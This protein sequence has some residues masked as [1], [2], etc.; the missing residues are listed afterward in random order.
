MPVTCC[1]L[2][3]H[4][5]T[6][7]NIRQ[8]CRALNRNHLWNFHCVNKPTLYNLLYC[9]FIWVFHIKNC[10][11]YLYFADGARNVLVTTDLIALEVRP[12]TLL[13]LTT[14]TSPEIFESNAVEGNARLTAGHL[15]SLIAQSRGIDEAPLVLLGNHV[16]TALLKMQSRDT[17]FNEGKW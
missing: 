17:D 5:L 2:E 12:G 16:K 11:L 15:M 9:D 3:T 4:S 13:R 6:A 10:T 14:Q 7:S 1:S 8:E